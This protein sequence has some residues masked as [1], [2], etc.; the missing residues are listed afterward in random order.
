MN[1]PQIVFCR[2]F[3]IGSMPI[4]K[5]AECATDQEAFRICTKEQ[6]QHPGYLYFWLSADSGLYE[7]ALPYSQGA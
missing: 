1:T 6:E 3:D 5:V 4:Y 7:D 2:R